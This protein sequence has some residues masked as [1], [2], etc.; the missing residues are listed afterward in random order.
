[1][2]MGLIKVLEMLMQKM[3]NLF[4]NMLD[5]GVVVFLDNIRI[6]S[7]TVEEHFKILEKVLTC[8]CSMHFTAS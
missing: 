7:T 1:M 8:L 3:N 6:Y 4:I 2:P 5:K